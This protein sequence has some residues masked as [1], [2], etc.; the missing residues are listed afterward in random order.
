VDDLKDRFPPAAPRHLNFL[1]HRE[2]EAGV[3]NSPGAARDFFRC[4]VE[5]TD[6]EPN[7]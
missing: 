6:K 7:P 4:A 3:E 5:R 1:P 2:I